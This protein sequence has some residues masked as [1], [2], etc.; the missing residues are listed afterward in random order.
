MGPYLVIAGAMLWLAA[1]TC[2]FII[3]LDAC[4]N[5]IWK[6]LLFVTCCYIYPLYYMFVEFDHENKWI[7][8]MTA[9]IGTSLGSGLVFLGKTI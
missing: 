6:G 2:L 8:V 1:A 3:V 9:L 5:R 4:R 7:V